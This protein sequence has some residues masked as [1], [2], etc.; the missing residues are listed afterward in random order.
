MKKRNIKLS[1]IFLIGAI[2]LQG[3]MA[4]LRTS[5]IKTSGVTVANANKGKA[6]LE[7]A[8]KKQ[9][10]DNLDKHKVYAF[11]GVD[12]WKGMMGKMG[13][14]WPDL[15]TS[16]DFKYQ[17]GTFDGQVSFADGK[18]KGMSAGLQNWHY[19]EKENSGAAKF[20]SKNKKIAFGIPAFHYFTEMIGR[21]KNAP[22]ISYAGEKEF[23]DQKYD[24]V[25]CTWNTDEPHMKADQYVAWIN[26]ATG[27]MDFTQYTLRD[28]YMKP[29]GHK[30]FYGGVEFS[31]FKN[32]DGVMIPHLHT[33]YI[34]KLKKKK[35]KFVHQ[36]VISDFQFD[37]F[38]IDELRPDK[39]IEEGGDF[40]TVSVK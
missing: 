36:L 16:L 35:K 14:I 25:F 34:N 18:K 27:M 13:K 39:S 33:I 21:L 20:I 29:P 40:K 28:N 5:T 2:L 6:I 19:Y 10:F 12:T 8:W 11:H 3:C 30:M 32:I 7:K 22:I 15:K 1:G 9:G 24:L 26:K 17:V 4:D 38:D 31:N 37:S 23:R